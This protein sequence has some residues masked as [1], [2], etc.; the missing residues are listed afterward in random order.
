[1][2]TMAASS[3]DVVDNNYQVLD[4]RVDILF[5]VDNSGSMDFHQ[6][7]LSANITRFMSAFF[8]RVSI[9]YHIGVVSTD[10]EQSSYG[11]CCGRL[12]GTPSYIQVSTP[13][14]TPD[15][16]T[17]LSTRL[18]LG[19]NGSASEKSF[20]AVMAALSPPM[21]STVNQGFLR[22]EAH[23]AV[24]F[25]TDAEDQSLISSTEL[26]NFLVKLKGKSEKVLAYGVI[27]P[28]G[29]EATNCH[30]DE[31]REPKFIEQFLSMTYNSGKNILNLCAADFG[32]KLSFMAKD[33]A[34]QVSNT[35][36]LNKTPNL[37]TLKVYFGTQ[38]IPNDASIGWSYDSS[39]NAIYFGD[40]LLLDPNQPKGTKITIDFEVVPI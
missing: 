19:I 34:G 29:A 20:D 6:Q 36:F 1:M 38:L 25:I 2:I 37:K 11:K 22:P 23:L 8:S 40:S 7:N 33:I 35:I 14:S 9:D 18:V 4:P 21:V 17:D 10:M 26:Y 13:L 16:V 39:L 30:R 32:D 24:I 28:S 12:I 3:I 5:V 15:P 27:I 31:P